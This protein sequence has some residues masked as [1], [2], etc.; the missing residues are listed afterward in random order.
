MNVI[1]PQE[2]TPEEVTVLPGILLQRKKVP[3][4]LVRGV[5]LVKKQIHIYYSG[6][7]QGVGFRFTAESIASDLSIT[8]WVK[9]LPDGRVEVVAEADEGTL[10]EFLSRIN[11]YFS[12]YIQDT[13]IEWLVASGEFKEFG[14][15]F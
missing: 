2:G 7:V 6:A 14:I 3:R 1:L 15:E 12:K 8:G 10:K 13:G 4:T 5:P 9:N 11:K